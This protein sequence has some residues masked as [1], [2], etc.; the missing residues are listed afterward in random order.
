[1]RNVLF[2]APH[3]DDEVVGSCILIRNLISE[4]KN[5]S[6]FFTSSGVISKNEMWFWSRNEYQK[7]K[8]IRQQEMRNSLNYLGINNFFF[9]DIPTRTLKDNILITYQKMLK[10]INFHKID[11]IFCPA[12][13]GGHQDHDV[14]NFICSRLK[15][16]CNVFEFS[17]YNFNNKK[18]NLN[19]FVSSIKDEKTIILNEMEKKFKKNCLE[20]Y[21]SEKPNLGYVSFEKETFR[22]IVDYDYS[23]PAHEGTL[24]YRRFK[25]FSWHPRVDGDQPELICNKIKQ[26]KIY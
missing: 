8:N 6:I 11:T 13:E 19:S 17:E 16:K 1:M 25:F 23:R 15:D 9:Q 14:S 21:V 7:K 20:F 5:V 12:Y 22:P 18:V 4:K 24:F 2:I 26:S 3:P 10:L